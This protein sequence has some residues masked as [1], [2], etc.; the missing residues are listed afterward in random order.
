MAVIEQV[1]DLDH[2]DVK[3]G[4]FV[5]IEMDGNE[6]LVYIRTHDSYVCL[7]NGITYPMTH[8]RVLASK[9]KKI[10]TTIHI[11]PT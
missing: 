8:Q 3:P 5:N 2:S 7:N 10:K 9:V 1:Y 11:K 6:N 4:E